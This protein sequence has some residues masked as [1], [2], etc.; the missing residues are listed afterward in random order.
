[1]AITD[2]NSISGSEQT[3]D[4]FINAL[5]QNVPANAVI[6]VDGTAYSQ[7]DLVKK[8]D[9]ERAF[10]K[11][12]RAAKETSKKAT[13]DLRIARP[14]IRKFLKA[15][16]IGMKAYLGADNPDIEKYG[17]HFDRTGE[18]SADQKAIRAEKSRRTREA[19]HTLG[20]RQKAGIHGAAEPDVTLHD[21]KA[22]A[23]SSN[24]GGTAS[25]P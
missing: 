14:G 7:Q 23:P 25:K 22:P 21:P 20:K 13:S 6:L 17:F 16:K 10:F 11:N 24:P 18:L 9:S 5:Q 3:L 4:T 8:A 19:R 2:K 15:A 1:M 12:A